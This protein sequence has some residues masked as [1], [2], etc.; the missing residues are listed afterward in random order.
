LAK[1]LLGE[2]N[3]AGADLQLRIIVEMHGKLE[4]QAEVLH[5]Q[6]IPRP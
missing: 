3:L 6:I 1:A 5:A 4:K 2:G